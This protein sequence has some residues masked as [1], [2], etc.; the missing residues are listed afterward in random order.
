MK[1]TIFKKTLFDAYLVHVLSADMEAGVSELAALHR[2]AIQMFSLLLVIFKPGLWFRRPTSWTMEQT[3]PFQ[4][5]VHTHSFTVN[6]CEVQS[7][8]VVLSLSSQYPLVSMESSWYGVACRDL[9]SAEEVCDTLTSIC[10]SIVHC[11]LLSRPKQSPCVQSSSERF[12][13]TLCGWSHDHNT[14]HHQQAVSCWSSW[15]TERDTSAP[16]PLDSGIEKPWGHLAPHK[17]WQL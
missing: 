4:P 14:H 16:C 3:E 7:Q 13:F 12:V 5:S 8:V 2:R 1:E 15:F 11:V 10:S 9:S 17:N 6:L